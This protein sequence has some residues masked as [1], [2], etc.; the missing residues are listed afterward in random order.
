MLYRS[1][2]TR[3]PFSVLLIKILNAYFKHRGVHFFNQTKKFASLISVPREYFFSRWFRDLIVW[4]FVYLILQL[5]KSQQS[6]I[7]LRKSKTITYWTISANEKTNHSGKQKWTR[8]D[9]LAALHE[10]STQ[11][12]ELP[13]VSV[14]WQPCHE[15]ERKCF[16]KKR[17]V[18]WFES[19]SRLKEFQDTSVG[20]F[21]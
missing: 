20:S 13:I 4:L 8:V 6:L 11:F 10:P 18:Q 19:F 14:L 5:Q 3:F 2:F 15:S 17:C 7:V 9:S 21:F 12:R 1:D 16:E